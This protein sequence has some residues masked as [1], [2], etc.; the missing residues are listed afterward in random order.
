M[1]K[2]VTEDDL[3]SGLSGFGDGLSTITEKRPR[4]DSPFRDTRTEPERKPAEREEKIIEI[5]PAGPVPERER[6]QIAPPQPE[7]DP[8]EELLERA[9]A[10]QARSARVTEGEG[11]EEPVSTQPSTI[12]DYARQVR[13]SYPEPPEPE[14][15]HVRKADIFTERVTLSVSTEMRD[16]V[17]ALAREMQRRRTKKEERITANTVMRVAIN[18]LLQSFDLEEGDVA[19]TEEELLALARL[20]RMRRR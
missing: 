12:A 13:V 3:A 15:P 4:R 6:S 18:A 7:R 5:R 8:H 20:K 10:A 14:A 1:A 16:A 9:R 19:N 11:R 2:H 17:E